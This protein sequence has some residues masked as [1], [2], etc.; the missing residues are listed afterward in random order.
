MEYPKEIINFIELKL[1][2][3]NYCLPHFYPENIQQIENF[4]D[5]YKFNS[6]TG[7]NL[8]GEKEGDFKENWLV[9]CSGYANDPFIVDISQSHSGYPVSFA[10]HGTGKWDLL[11]VTDSLKYFTEQLNLLKEIELKAKDRQLEMEK[12]FDLTQPFWK[13]VYN[14]YFIEE[15]PANIQKELSEVDKHRNALYFELKQLNQQK[16]KGEI[17]LKSFLKA[18]RILKLKL[19]AIKD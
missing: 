10:W 1:T 12:H 3:D 4:Q 5:G 17:D 6:L 13:E 8:I 2:L 9:I 18:K 11:L 19:D 14:E 7:K 16:E 15:E